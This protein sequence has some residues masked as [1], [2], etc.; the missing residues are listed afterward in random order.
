MIIINLPGTVAHSQSAK[1]LL[2]GYSK[3]LWRGKLMELDHG[4]HTII[5][6]KGVWG[7]VGNQPLASLGS[8]LHSAKVWPVSFSYSLQSLNN[9][10]DVVIGG[11]DE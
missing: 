10:L 3:L 5:H 7:A 2:S 1:L 4:T 9:A 11:G 6:L 8:M